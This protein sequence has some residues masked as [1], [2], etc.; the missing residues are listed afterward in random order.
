MIIDSVGHR[1]TVY[2]PTPTNKYKMK[3]TTLIQN[4][5]SELFIIS[6]SA[7]KQSSVTGPA[8]S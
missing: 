4:S 3:V 2:F 6:C 7:E 8:T 5:N 1:V